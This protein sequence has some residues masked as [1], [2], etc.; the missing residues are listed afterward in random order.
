MTQDASDITGFNPTKPDEQLH[1]DDPRGLLGQVVADRYEVLELLGVGGMGSVYRARHIHIRK[2]V[3]LKTLHAHMLRSAEVVA[4]FEREAVAAARIDHPNV[5]VAT[6]FGRLPNGRHYLVLEFVEGHDLRHELDSAGAFPTSRALAIGRQI[7]SGLSAAHP[8][9][10]IHR[11]LKPENVMLVNRGS[12]T[13]LVKVLDFGIAKMT[14]ED[15][16]QPLT[17]LGAVFGTPQYMSPEQAKGHSVDARSDLYS[18]GVILFEMLTGRLP[19]DAADA[20]GFIVQH[21][22]VK[23][24]PLP[25]SVPEPL[26][27]LV[28]R[29]LEKDPANRPA[30]A[31]EVVR[32]LDRL[33]HTVGSQPGCASVAMESRWR[34]RFARLHAWAR[35]IL[36]RRRRIGRLTLTTAR[37]LAVGIGI[38]LG[39]GLLLIRGTSIDATKAQPSIEE[40]LLPA[41][42]STLL[43]SPIEPECLREIERIEQLRVYQR[44]E[45][46]WMLLA[47]CSTRV[48]HDEQAVLAYQA[49]LSLRPQLHRDPGLLTDLYRISRDPKAMRVV[50]NLCESVLGR[51]GVDLLWLMWERERHLPDHREQAEKVAKKLVILSLRASPALRAAIELSFTTNCDK[52]LSVL[53]R[54]A[55]EADSRSHAR[56][57]ALS[58]RTGCGS[59]QSEDCF[60]C[61]RES[62]MLEQ[63]TQR[64][65][66]TPAP[67]LGG[68]TA[69]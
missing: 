46:D 52:L 68:T 55:T 21:L 50:V 31:D 42:P 4:R 27:G 14:A 57:R 59:D 9:G 29:L 35:P 8:M 43:P 49:L 24:A 15:K 12:N 47:R 32:E 39:F 2:Q 7:A 3:A 45:R 33:A 40:S 54:A 26:C 20:L 22:T 64:A 16:S 18:L 6:D 44:N 60:A 37:W 48:G 28:Q 62:P 67:V 19:F 11:D 1:E 17:Q 30:T 65:G 5:I 10:I 51:Y 63:A 25:S 56:L 13:E 41:S 36:Q 53:E 23:P 69:Q 61:I 66:K 38:M 58:A 34:E